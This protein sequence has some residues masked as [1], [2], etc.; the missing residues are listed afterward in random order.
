ESGCV[1]GPPNN[2]L[3]V[4]LTKSAQDVSEAG[5]DKDFR[6]RIQLLLLLL[7]DEVDEHSTARGVWVTGHGL[8]RV[9]DYRLPGRGE[10]VAFL[11]TLVRHMSTTTPAHVLPLAA[12]E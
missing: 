3:I 7:A 11:T 1:F 8:I 9:A 2:R 10:A 5:N 4:E 6:Q 12:L